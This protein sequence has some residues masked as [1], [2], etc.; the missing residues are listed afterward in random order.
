[1]AERNNLYPIEGVVFTKLTQEFTYKKGTKKGQQGESRYIVL[2][3]RG[4]GN[5]KDYI[6]FHKFKVVNPS[7]PLDDFDKGNR[8]IITFALGGNEWKDG[9]INETKAVY[10]RHADIQGDDTRDLRQQTPKKAP[11]WLPPDPTEPDDD[12]PF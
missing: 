1:M 6:D 11:E 5:G 7:V 8:V 9:F 3:I 4:N 12:L 2:E 10:I